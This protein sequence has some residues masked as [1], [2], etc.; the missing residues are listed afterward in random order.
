MESPADSRSAEQTVP[1]DYLAKDF[2]S[3]LVALSNFSAAR[4]PAWTERSEADFGVMLMEALSALADELSYLQDRAAAEATIGTATQ[5]LSLGRA[6][7]PVEYEPM[8]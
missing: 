4:Y 3:F 5:R 7:R 8:P 1:V 2:T 6:G